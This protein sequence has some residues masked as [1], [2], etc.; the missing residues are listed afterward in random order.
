VAFDDDAAATTQI[1]QVDLSE[2]PK[3]LLVDDD[4]LI[5]ERLASLIR[6]AG[7]EVETALDGQT[8]LQSLEGDF[9]PIVI[10]DRR[11]PGMD[12]LALCRA[13]RN[14]QWAGYVYIVLLTAQ[15]SED[16]ILAGLNAGADDYLGKRASSAQLLARL[17]TAQRILSLEHSLKQALAEKRRLSLIDPLTGAANR[18]YFLQ[19]LEREL[20][21]AQSS[22]SPLS[23][24]CLDIDHFK[25]I[26]DRY[27][28]AA[29]DAVLQEFVRRVNSQLNKPLAPNHS[30]V[31][32]RGWCARIGGEEFV[33]VLGRADREDAYKVAEAIRLA[34]ARD[35][36][37]T[38]GGIVRF[39]VSIGVS[40]W[41]AAHSG[42]ANT[43][44]SLLQ[45]GDQALYESKANGRNRTTL[46][47]SGGQV[48]A[49]I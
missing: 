18:R 40:V 3:V 27:G 28:H 11:M 17:R 10:T 26:N 13:I 21:H 46:A 24:L 9:A 15:D 38:T 33:V 14:K 49:G 48:Q 45:S 25:Q 39:T 2:M 5:L 34:V 8:A 19:R 31:A 16:D 37:R 29:G 41:R 35:P 4:E 30:P 42:T 43:S 1:I 32:P 47:S 7:F 44:E 23:L 36:A 12:G 20:R 6:D 22:A